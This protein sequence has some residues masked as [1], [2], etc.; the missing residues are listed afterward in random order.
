MP[1]TPV[2][3]VSVTLR[4]DELAAWSA[5][6]LLRVGSAAISAAAVDS[7][8]VASGNIF[9]ALRGE[10]TDGHRFLEAAVAAGAA[11]LVVSE[12]PDDVRLDGLT[13]T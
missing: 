5:G 3:R 7:R 10:H 1:T 9:F 2:P 4:P 6:R 12:V 8:R 11:A 13:R